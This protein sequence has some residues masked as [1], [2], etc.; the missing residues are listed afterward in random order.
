MTLELP[1]V[2]SGMTLELPSVG[3]CM[4]RP[5]WARIAFVGLPVIEQFLPV[6]YT[7]WR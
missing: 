3:S 5:R 1:S 4:C 6:I 2:G 7:G